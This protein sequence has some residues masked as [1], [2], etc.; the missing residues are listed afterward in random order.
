MPRTGCRNR[1]R[2]SVFYFTGRQ[3]RFKNDSPARHTIA[4]SNRT[5]GRFHLESNFAFRPKSNN[6][7]SLLTYQEHKSIS[8][9][10]T[11]DGEGGGGGSGGGDVASSNFGGST[12]GGRGRNGGGGRSKGGPHRRNWGSGRGNGGEGVN[13]G[14]GQDPADRQAIQEF[15]QWVYEPGAPDKAVEA[16]KNFEADAFM[17]RYVR[18]VHHFL[19]ERDRRVASPRVTRSATTSTEGNPLA[20]EGAGYDDG[21]SAHAL[22]EGTQGVYGGGDDRRD[23]VGNDREPPPE[24]VCNLQ[25]RLGIILRTCENLRDVPFQLHHQVYGNRQLCSPRVRVLWSALSLA[26]LSASWAACIRGMVRSSYACVRGVYARNTLAHRGKFHRF[27]FPF[28]PPPPPSFL[29]DFDRMLSMLEETVLH[30]GKC[31]NAGV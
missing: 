21:L 18:Q 20:R 17:P 6:L 23:F 2:V 30:H 29:L 12:R 25:L 16:Q 11:V 27:F 14:A 5:S 31:T 13:S 9:R 15:Q 24:Q 1:T 22:S 4:K 26:R 19:R 7:P 28:R 10:T 3:S 8:R